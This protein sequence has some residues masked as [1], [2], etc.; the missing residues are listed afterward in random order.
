MAE[1]EPVDGFPNLIVVLVDPEETGNV[2]FTVRAMANFGV[3]RLRIV[4]DDI[5]EDQ[6]AHIFAVR[7]VDILQRAEVFETLEEAL[8]DV[9]AAWGA[10][11]RKGS[12]HS[13]TRAT[14]LVSQLPD[15]TSIPATVALVFGRE[16]VGLT[17]D[18]LALCD[19][20]F[21]I[22]TSKQYGSLNLSH[23]V[24]VTLYELYN[25]YA[26]RPERRPTD[27]RPAT[28]EEREQAAFFFDELIDKTT[29]KDFRIPIAK[30]VFRNLLH[31]A[32]MTG[33]EIATLTG[34]IRKI[35]KIVRAQDEGSEDLNSTS[36]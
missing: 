10:T 17:N 2:G 32:F 34:T 27:I 4:G 30:Q 19:I 15:P 18:E 11:A 26:E 23:A 3:D 16:S 21:N 5:R 13:V 25:K 8:V 14:P 1:E 29:I 36:R 33:R 6:Y 20:A 35:V 28:R 9:E 22:P 7:A 24:A 31:R 12:N